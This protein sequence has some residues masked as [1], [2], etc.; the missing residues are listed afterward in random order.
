MAAS[1]KQGGGNPE[2]PLEKLS[3]LLGK[4]WMLLLGTESASAATWMFVI[5][6]MRSALWA[7]GVLSVVPHALVFAF[8][9]VMQFVDSF[10]P[11]LGECLPLLSLR[12]TEAT[13]GRLSFAQLTAII[14][15][16]R[17]GSILGAVVFKSLIPIAPPEVSF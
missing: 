2:G 6:S 9:A 11:F 5:L 14:P 13:M 10:V 15:A 12:I 1:N 17:I 16:H 7:A 3:N 4:P 8:P